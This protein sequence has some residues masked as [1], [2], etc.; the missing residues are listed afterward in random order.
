[1]DTKESI[2]CELLECGSLDLD[3]LSELCDKNN[4]ELDIE[5][6]RQE[7]WSININIL[8]YVALRQIAQE[9]ITENEEEICNILKVSDLEE[10]ISNNDLYETFTNC[11]DSHLRFINEEIQELFEKSKYQ[12]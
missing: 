7:Y 3:Y 4:I 12:V 1:M 6:I 11:M 5:S 9:F 8:I 2:V 10:Y